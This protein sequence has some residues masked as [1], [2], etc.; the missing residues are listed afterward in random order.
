MLDQ[1]QLDV[2]LLGVDAV[3]PEWGAMTH[4]E[5]EAMINRMLADRARQVILVADSTK[6]GKRAFAR[7]RPMDRVDVLVTD[8]QAD[9]ELIKRF[10]DAGVRVVTA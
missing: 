2:A 4:N 5:G 8:D 10:T 6:L 3:D 7:I 1:L 9:A